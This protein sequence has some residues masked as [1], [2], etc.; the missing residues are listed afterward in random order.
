MSAAEAPRRDLVRET[1]RRHG[2]ER[3]K[4]L[5]RD[6]REAPGIQIH[7]HRGGALLAPE[8]T[9]AAFAGA[10]DLGVD[11]I[12]LDVRRCATGELVVIH[13]ADL[14]RVGGVDRRVDEL[15]LDELQSI[16]VGSHFGPEYAD[17]RVPTLVEVVEACDIRARKG[18]SLNIEVKE[19]RGRGD[20]T[21]LAL[22][23]MI[24]AMDLYGHVVVGSF[25]PL[26]LA[27]V[28]SRCS[29]PLS[30]I[31]PSSGTTVRERLMRRPWA[32]S[33]LSLY[34]LHPSVSVVTAETVRKAHLRGLA[35]NV[36]TVN[37]EAKMRELA[38]WRVNGMITDRPDIAMNV[39]LELDA[40]KGNQATL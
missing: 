17:Q 32:S 6:P 3:Q 11:F 27:R 38:S 7:A 5:K 36:W 31:Y 9:L 25:N 10:M 13:D 37:D 40:L 15:S 4:S 34:A 16:D 30:L 29:A 23:S 26:S 12:E 35:V 19:E 21:A 28:R 1:P 8:N 18:V 20:G 33:V 39:V 24:E 22:G 2:H 14:A